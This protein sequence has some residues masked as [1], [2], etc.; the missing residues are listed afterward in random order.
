MASCR[1][2]AAGSGLRVADLL[3]RH[4]DACLRRFGDG[5]GTEER[6]AL[7]SIH[8]C[9]TPAMGGRSYRCAHCERDHFAW[10]S[11][12]HRLCPVCGSAE[13]ASWV[14]GQLDARLP[15]EHFLVTFTLPSAL[16]SP[17]RREPRRFLSA[18]FAASSQAV[19][20]VLKQRRHLGGE[21]GFLGVLQTWT[22]DLRLHPHIHYIVPAV[23]IGTDGKVRRSRKP[24]WLARGEVFAARLRSLLLKSLAKEGLLPE[25]EAAPLWRTTWNCDVEAF[26]DGANAIKYLGGYLRKG[27]ISDSRILGESNGSVEI[28]VRD[29]KT[30][31]RRAVGVEAA[32][33]RSL[34]RHCRRHIRPPLPAACP[35]SRLSRDPT[36]RLHASPGGEEARIDPTPARRKGRGQGR[37]A[38]GAGA[39]ARAAL[40]PLPQAHGA[41]RQA[42]PRPAAGTDH[43]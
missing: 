1:S 36:L 17:C 38:D 21:C 13:T 40:P 24:G 16:R 39:V 10:R 31:E 29:R 27:P 23:G 43:P 14:A 30:G 41:D 37:E 15:V 26:G 4:A 19:K 32:V 12:N 25:S 11:C 18:F 33:P 7:Q 22:Q 35:A 8:L 20:D 2:R 3:I 42:Q 5:L 28:S 34:R 9:R 6:R